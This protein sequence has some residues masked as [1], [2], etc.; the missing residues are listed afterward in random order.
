MINVAD[1][2]NEKGEEE[3][4]RGTS[5]TTTKP[6]SHLKMAFSRKLHG[7]QLLMRLLGVGL[8]LILTLIMAFCFISVGA[9]AGDASSA[10]D[11]AFFNPSQ[12]L[13]LFFY[14][15]TLLSATGIIGGARILWRDEQQGGGDNWRRIL[16]ELQ[17]E[18]VLRTLFHIP[19]HLSIYY[20]VQRPSIHHQVYHPIFG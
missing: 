9:G 10:N 1:D 17:S 2:G 16:A 13:Q 7:Q 6:K 4:K 14:Y 8:T 20:I 15:R 18:L 11:G 12:I 3:V 19:G 5:T